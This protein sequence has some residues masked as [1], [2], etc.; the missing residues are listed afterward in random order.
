MGHSA[1]LTGESMVTTH[2]RISRYLPLALLYLPIACTG[3]V[4][5]APSG[6]GSEPGT[7]GGTGAVGGTPPATPGGPK[8]PDG[9]PTGPTPAACTGVN[10]GASP[11]RRMTHVEYNNAIAD[12]LGDKSAP[13]KG[14]PQD[15]QSGLF[16][17]TAAV[18][19]VPPLL[20]EG[21]LNTA[22]QLA[23]RADV[24]A[25][26]GCDTAATSCVSDFIQK[27]GR[28][29][30]R[31]PLQPAE[32][33][34]LQQVYDGAKA[35]SDADTGMRAVVAS[36]LMA[37]QFLYYFEVGGQDSGTAGVKKLTP[38][39]VAA[40]LGSLL[41]ASLPDNALLDAAAAGQLN[42][43]EQVA[44]QVTR[45]LKDPRARV[46]T[47]VFYEQWFGV[48]EL[49]TANKDTMLYP[50]F[51]ELRA[52]MREET[53]RFLNHVIWEGDG[54][55]STLLSAPFS[56][57]DAR[58]AALYGVPAPAGQGFQRVSLDPAMRGGILTQA[59][60]LSGFSGMIE[61]SPFKRGAMLRTRILCQDLPAPPADVPPLPEQKAGQTNRQ[62]A[63]EHT[64]SAACF[65]CHK[66]IDGLGFGLEQYDVIGQTRTMEHGLPVDS[67]GDVTGTTDIDGKFN[68]GAE[69]ARLLA[70]SA[71]VRDCA[72]TQWLRYAL[73]RHEAAEDAC[74]LQQLK[75]SFATSD[76]NLRD[77]LLAVT[78][79][80]AF[81]H[82]RR[83]EGP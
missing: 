11:V 79:T 23:E 10:V 47:N 50:Q 53:V 41:W 60:L 52:S 46:A 30:F 72:P 29:A 18:Q 71:Q 49:E 70:K 37:P 66:M 1:N 81:L 42:T 2:P 36:V 34:R 65:S 9:K 64:K 48:N 26:A 59:S 6:P 27:F 83:P 51:G 56:F 58:L 3:Q 17:N 40:R 8:G 19:S 33:Q 44:T 16:N 24:K 31:R 68:G 55:L 35:K 25:L 4:G 57:V 67:R 78:Q 63:E 62:R 7:A 14:F 73:S 28:R 38:F 13:A 54:K 82:Y 15:N 32:A 39:E 43:R 22:A 80:D 69:L 77:L 61:T 76:G 45:M 74:S 5:E 21:Y 75:T 12:L 20:A